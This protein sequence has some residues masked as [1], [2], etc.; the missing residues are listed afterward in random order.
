VIVLVLAL[1]LSL[2]ALQGLV[3]TPILGA[4][5]LHFIVGVVRSSLTTSIGELA[6]VLVLAMPF[7]AI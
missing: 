2:K 7:N 1:V 4:K 6:L 5:T 3:T